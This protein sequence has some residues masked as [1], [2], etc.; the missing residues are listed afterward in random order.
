MKKKNKIILIILICILVVS[1]SAG[2]IYFVSKKNSDKTV[3]V[4]FYG[5]PQDICK[6]IQEEFTNDLKL[7]VQFDILADD[8]L[9]LGVVTKKYDMFFAWNGEVTQTL[10][11][12]AEKIHSK[13]M[14]NIPISLRNEYCVPV[15]LDHYE[16]AVNKEIVEKIQINPEE[17]FQSFTDFLHESSKYVFSPFFTDGGNDEVLLSLVGS[18][19][20]SLGGSEAYRNLINQMQTYDKLDDFVDTGLNDSGFS[21]SD[22]LN[23]IKI[24]PKEE[25]LHPQWT[26]ANK[27]DLEIFS[28]QNQ[29]AAFYINLSEHRKIPFHVINKFTAIKM[30]VADENTPHCI[31][32][33]AVCCVLIT[34]NS[35]AKNY[36]KTLL[37]LECQ[38][39]LSDKT[40]LAPVHYRAEAFD[41]LSDD[42]RF[43][44]ASCEDGVMPNLTTAV[45]Q[46]KQNKI[47]EIANEIRAYLK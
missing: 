22:V 38:T 5:L 45:Y 42:V 13:I 3:N 26:V 32:A 30:P 4:A 25:L 2:V 11:S 18:F 46:R 40:M 6:S 31:I 1:I 16:I 8:N 36:L 9:D 15:L 44:A 14:E 12:S 7:R 28:E 47:K 37:N 23:M 43:W 27:K 35:N 21:L 17:S 19:T 24:W 39:R 33:P 10:S 34:D 20:E 41:S 29:I